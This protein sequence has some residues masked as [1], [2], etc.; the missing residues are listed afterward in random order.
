MSRCHARFASLLWMALFTLSACADPGLPWGWVEAEVQGSFDPDEGRLDDEG[1]LKTSGN[2]ALALDTVEV[3]FDALTV[4]LAGAGTADF[5]P[6][7]P[8]EGYSLC[9]NGHCHSDAGAL[10]DYEIIAL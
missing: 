10:V 1:R 6:A 9:H 5:D 3:T 7:N 4:V 8:P 2:Y